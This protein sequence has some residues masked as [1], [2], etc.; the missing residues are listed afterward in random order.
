MMSVTIIL[1]TNTV[2]RSYTIMALTMN[3]YIQVSQYIRVG[4]ESD[5]VG[6]LRLAAPVLVENT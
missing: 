6:Y 4:F 5:I 2:V 1:F 3:K